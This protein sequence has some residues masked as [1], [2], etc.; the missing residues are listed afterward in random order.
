MGIKSAVLYHLDPG[1]F[2]ARDSRSL[3]GF[4]LLSGCSFFDLPS[5]SSEFVMYDPERQL[6]MGACMHPTTFGIL[7][8]F[9][10]STV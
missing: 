4:Y 5:K 9:S 8:R 1:Y 7:T 2:P 6:K 10:P 3:L